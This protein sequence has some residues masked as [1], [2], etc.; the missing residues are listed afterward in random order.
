MRLTTSFFVFASICLPQLGHAADI[1]AGK[2]IFDTTC[3]NCHSLAVG[4]NKVGPSLWHVVGRPSA[5]VQG[6]EY[7]DA[8]KSLHGE[9]TPATLNEYLAN[10]RAD[11]HGV[12]MFFKGLPGQRDRANVIAYLESQQ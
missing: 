3:H 1:A 4:V 2:S 9:W 6:Y 11:V 10:P 5:S 8:M 7:S 12:N